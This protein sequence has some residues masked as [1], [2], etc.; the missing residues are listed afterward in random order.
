MI[1]ID[2][3]DAYEEFDGNLDAWI[4]SEERSR[5]DDNAWQ[6]IEVILHKMHLISSG[7]AS[8]KFEAVFQENLLTL[9]ENDQVRNR[10]WTLVKEPNKKL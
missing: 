1:T 2:K 7:L 4:H 10:L 9:T 3:L 6:S 8:D 5:I